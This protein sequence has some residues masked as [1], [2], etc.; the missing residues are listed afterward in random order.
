MGIYLTAAEQAREC[1]FCSMPADEHEQLDGYLHRVWV[2]PYAPPSWR[3]VFHD[4]PV[5]TAD[6]QH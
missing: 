2:C 1:P 3:G 6:S 5:N 4:R